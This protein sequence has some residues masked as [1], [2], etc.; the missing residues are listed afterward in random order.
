MPECQPPRKRFAPSTATVIMLMYSAIWMRAKRIDEYSVW[1]P[2]TSSVSP[3]GQVE[4]DARHLGG[5][6]DEVDEEGGELHEGVPAEE[7][8][9]EAR[10][11]VVHDVA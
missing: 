7:P 2:A 8:A 1:K 5:G 4:G 10:A 11:L 3:S 6:G 9:A